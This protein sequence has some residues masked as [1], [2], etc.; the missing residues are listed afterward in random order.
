M[1]MHTF[2]FIS[3]QFMYLMFGCPTLVISTHLVLLHG[4]MTLPLFVSPLSQG[5]PALRHSQRADHAGADQ[6]EDLP[7]P[8]PSQDARLQLVWAHHQRDSNHQ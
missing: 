5:A 7:G 8:Q 2:N 4:L 3:V 1:Y 6:E